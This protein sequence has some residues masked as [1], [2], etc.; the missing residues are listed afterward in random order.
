MI[1]AMSIPAYAAEDTTITNS[2]GRTYNGYK[3]LS[4]TTSLNC[5][6]NHTHVDDCYNYAYTVNEK[7]RNI[8]Q[9]QAG[10]GNDIIEYLSGL[11]SD[12]EDGEYGTLRTVADDIYRA[13]LSANIPADKS[14]MTGNSTIEQGYWLFADVSELTGNT[15]NSLVMLD[16]KGQDALAI[17][18]K[19][20][21][22]TLEKKVQDT[23]DTT[24]ETTG[25]QDS[26][27]Y[28]IGDTVPFQITVTMPENLAGY[29]AYKI[30]IHDTMSA[31]LTLNVSSIRVSVGTTDVTDDFI[32]EAGTGGQ[33]TLTCDDVLSIDGLTVTKDTVF[34]VTYNATLNEN[35]VIGAAGN[36]NTAYLEYSNN[37][38][39]NGTGTTVVDKVI[40]FT[41]QLTIN[42]V[43]EQGNPL[44]G[45]GFTLY[46]KGTDGNFAPI[47]EQLVGGDM[48]TFQWEGL[49]DGEYKLVETTVPNGYNKLE[50][51]EFTITAEHNEE[52]DDP[53]L[54]SLTSTFG[55]VDDGIISDDIENKTGTVLPET[56]AQG[57]MML[58]TFST[59][60]IMATAVFMITRKKMSIYED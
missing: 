50:D 19:V 13:I 42:K 15:A 38:Y 54:I 51:I 43:D 59:M 23:N 11:T 18:P 40:V 60:I 14:G 46:K 5:E 44:K 48:T 28:D 45:A 1:L 55:N 21:L 52:S 58:L 9:A 26:A 56:G 37:P 57:T 27:D 12:S 53:Q 41:Y 8:L 22:P 20:G 4:L 3:L 24:G 30:V 17:R 29:D 6:E 25:W 7:Y 16:T 47:G 33:F 10:T 32:Y 39:G 34:V 2:T 35:A 36:P 31:G 49:D